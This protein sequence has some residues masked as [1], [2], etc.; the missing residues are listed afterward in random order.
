MQIVHV[1]VHVKPEHIDAFIAATLEN[2]RNSI[3]EPGIARFD[4]VQQ[5][6]EPARFVLVEA[7]R[8]ADAPALH[9]E[10]AHYLTWRDTVA[11]MMAEPRTSVKFTNI[12]P[13]E[14]GW[15]TP[16]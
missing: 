4:F 6:D 16:I 3:R 8:S 9:K 12:F 2:A 1:F 11:P 5:T 7:Y 13:G 14:K 10:T 15:D